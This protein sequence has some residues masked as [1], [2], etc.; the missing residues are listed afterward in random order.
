MDTT[1]LLAG[2]LDI[3]PAAGAFSQCKNSLLQNEFMHIYTVIM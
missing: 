3:I 1:F 2:Q